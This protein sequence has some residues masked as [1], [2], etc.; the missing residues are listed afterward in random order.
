MPVISVPT[1]AKEEIPV[2]ESARVNAE[3][4]ENSAIRYWLTKNFSDIG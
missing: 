2:R 1:Q 4:L 3:S